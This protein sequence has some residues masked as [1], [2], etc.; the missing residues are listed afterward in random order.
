MAALPIF[1]GAVVYIMI[2]CND[3]LFNLAEKIMGFGLNMR[4]A[5][6]RQVGKKLF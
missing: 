2:L 5:D 1:L 3:F 4:R 6:L